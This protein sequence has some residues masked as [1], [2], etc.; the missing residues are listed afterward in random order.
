[1]VDL[2]TLRKSFAEL[3]PKEPRLFSAPGRVNLIGEHTD[4]NGGFVLPMAANLR[5]YVAAALRD[6]NQVN[7]CSVDKD[8]RAS[9]SLG[10]SRMAEGWPAY[11]HGMT[12]TLMKRGLK[13][14]GVD[15]A[16]L[17]EVPI[18]AG[19]SSSA[20]LEISVGFALTEVA[21]WK[22]NLLDLALAAQEAEHAYV[23]T[24]SGLMDQLTATFA[25]KNHAMFIDCRSNQI[26]QIPM[27]LPATEVV[28]CDTKVKHAL[29]SSSYNERRQECEHAVKSLQAEKPEVKSLSDLNTTDLEIIN[30]L[31]EPERRRAR[32][33]VT[34]NQ[35]TIQAAEALQ[36]N[37]A[38]GLG[39]LMTKSHVSLRDD[40]EVSSRELDIMFELAQNQ[41]GVYGGRMM[42]GG[43][44]GCTINL[45]ELESLDSFFDH[46]TAGYKKATG[47]FPNVAVVRTDNGVS[48][49]VS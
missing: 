47:I 22:I 10:D 20:A 14:S 17:S 5:T 45:V 35:R 42:G 25:K 6:D 23:G 46:M 44:G 1:M 28:I 12:Q 4:Y 27:N 8:A 18:G 38:E 26:T 33:V 37:D 15:L 41:R 7:V 36:R 34:E 30:Q 24:N 16:I 19:L 29:V 32:H 49:L 2:P 48:E 3:S 43:F 31:P 40:F 13:F 39:R 11:I 21:G 9:F